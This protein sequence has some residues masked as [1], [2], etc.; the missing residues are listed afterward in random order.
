MGSKLTNLNDLS[1]TD[2]VQHSDFRLPDFPD[3]TKI[4][5]NSLP[6]EFL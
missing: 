4:V 2:D 5:L 3:L 1:D 6:N